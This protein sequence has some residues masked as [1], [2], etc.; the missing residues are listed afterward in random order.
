M[1]VLVTFTEV[2]PPNPGTAGGVLTSDLRSTLAGTTAPQE[3][4]AVHCG[5]AMQIVTPAVGGGSTSYTFAPGD[6]GSI[7]LPPV[8][9]CACGFQLDAWT[10]GET[11]SGD[12]PAALA[13]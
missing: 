2:S 6:A 7:E 4:P 1:S 10:P 8:W 12:R 11:R 9:R 5:A 3:N 13:A